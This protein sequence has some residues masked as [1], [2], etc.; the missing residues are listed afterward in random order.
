MNPN[1]YLTYRIHQ[2]YGGILWNVDLIGGV[3]D[4]E[5]RPPGLV[6]KDTVYTYEEFPEW[7]QGKIALLSM[8]KEDEEVDG[9]GKRL[10]SNV[11]WVYISESEFEVE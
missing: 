3:L 2:F 5:F 7:L 10:S 1:E 9:V 11:L 8:M 4:I 6:L